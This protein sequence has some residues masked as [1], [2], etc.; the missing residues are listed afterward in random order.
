MTMG[1]VELFIVLAI[2][3]PIA[4]VVTLVVLIIK[5]GRTQSAVGMFTGSRRPA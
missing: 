2:L 4:L 5:M 1:P 3:A